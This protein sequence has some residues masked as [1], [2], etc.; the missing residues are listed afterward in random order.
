VLL[1]LLHDTPGAFE[2]FEAGLAADPRNAELYEGVATTSA[3]LGRPA[4]DRAAALERYPDPAHMP[5]PL[6]YNLAL[7]YAEAG[8][9]QK[10]GALFRNR[11]FPRE[12]GGT[13]VR[14]IWIR[15]RALEAES[16]AVRGQC[17]EAIAILDHLKNPVE[18]LTFTRDGLDVFIDQPFNQ[19]L[20]VSVDSRC[21]R[22]DAAAQRSAALARRSDPASL[23][24]AHA[25][26]ARLEAAVP[27]QIA[28]SSWNAA[29]AGLIEIELGHPGKAIPLL[30]S[31]L[32]LPDRNLSHHLSRVALAR[33]K[34]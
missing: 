15:V 24:F 4:A 1:R 34:R 13:N 17:D 8:A 31:A 18:G 27:R 6:V 2:A 26:A 16:K 20:F 21:G 7:S 19:A 32:L 9:F 3:I 25:D 23:V 11:F 33:I 29:L 14:Q 5:T 30:E 28:N 12:E 10:A 22:N